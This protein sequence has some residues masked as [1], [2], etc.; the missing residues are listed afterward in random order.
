MKM[1]GSGFMIDEGI[2]WNAT[3][4][5]L[6]LFFNIESDWVNEKKSLVAVSLTLNQAIELSDKLKSIVEFKNSLK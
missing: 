6:E 2:E 1:C 5:D 3:P 4:S